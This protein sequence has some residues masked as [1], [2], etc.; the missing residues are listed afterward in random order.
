MDFF[1][2]L[3][4]VAGVTGN[5]GQSNYACGNTYQDALGRYRTS[6]GE[7]AVSIDLSRVASVGFLA[8][9]LGTATAVTPSPAY[10][11][12]QESELHA[13]LDHY[14]DPSS[15]VLSPGDSQLVIGIH[16]PADLARQGIDE[17]V[18]MRWPL[19]SHLRHV[20]SSSL[21]STTALA[22]NTTSAPTTNFQTLF[23]AAT[24]RDALAE[25]VCQAL[26]HRLAASLAISNQDI[27]EDRPMHVYG[28]DSLVAV[29]I[30][31]WFRHEV[32]AEVAVVDVFESGSVRALSA[33]AAERSAFLK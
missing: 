20:E 9:R 12:I 8:E 17:P 19:F 27:D 31:Q 13:L 6:I 5:K 11:K 18:W 10:M 25:A 7:K 33:L 4:S 23:R 28:I 16:T 15:P 2:L 24:T 1:V 29:E 21:S 26:V 14:C 22:P 3:S 30:R 32:R